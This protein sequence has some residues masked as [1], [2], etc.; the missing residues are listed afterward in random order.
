MGSHQPGTP[1]D[2]TCRWAP[3]PMPVVGR[4]GSAGMSLSTVGAN[5][6]ALFCTRPESPS[7]ALA[8]NSGKSRRQSFVR[9]SARSSSVSSRCMSDLA[10]AFSSPLGRQAMHF[11]MRIVS[12]VLLDA[13]ALPS[14]RNTTSFTSAT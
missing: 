13:R 4:G 11:Q 1:N 7:N 14:G 9:Y 3:R 2:A 6:T 10:R 5:E 12:S 8:G